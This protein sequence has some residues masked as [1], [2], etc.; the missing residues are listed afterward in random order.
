MLTIE[1]RAEAYRYAKQ[2]KGDHGADLAGHLVASALVESTE[3]EAAYEK[4]IADLKDSLEAVTRSGVENAKRYAADI[5]AERRAGDAAVERVRAALL[6]GASDERQREVL[7]EALAVVEETTDHRAM[8]RY[9]ARAYLAL[10]A[11][12]AEA[13]ALLGDIGARARVLLDKAPT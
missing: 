13:R 11:S 7:A 3:R 12:H 9:V 2:T 6:E 1:E 8:A 4:R 5:A 10:S